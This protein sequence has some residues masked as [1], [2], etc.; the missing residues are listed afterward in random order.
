MGKEQS[1]KFLHIKEAQNLTL[2]GGSNH[3]NLTLNTER[4][5]Q[6]LQRRP[7]ASTLSG[8][9]VMV[10][11]QRVMVLM[12]QVMEAL[13]MLVLCWRVWKFSITCRVSAMLYGLIYTLSLSY[14]KS[15]KHTFEV[16]QK[17][18]KDLDS[19]KLSP[20]VQALKLKLLQ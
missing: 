9:R 19:T 3:K 18:L 14:P 5:R 13:L 8:Q 1:P 4:L 7:W 12:V 10:R 15:L 11:G 2:S 17:I 6:T 20:K 16:Y